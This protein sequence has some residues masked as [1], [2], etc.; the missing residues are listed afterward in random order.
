MITKGEKILITGAGGF[1]GANL[2]RRLIKEKCEVHALVKKNSNPWRLVDV[3]ND[4]TFQFVDLSDAK[5]LSIIVR[6]I[7]PRRVFHLATHGAYAAQKDLSQMIETNIIGT[8]NLLSALLT[9]PYVSFVNTGTSSEYG[10]KKK[11][12]KESDVL[13]PTSLYAA[14]KASSTLIAQVFAKIYHTSIVTLRPFSAYGPWEEP[15]RLVPTAM[16]AILKNSSIDLTPGNHRRDFIFVEDLIDAYLAASDASSKVSGM[17]F[18][19]GTGKQYT[20]DQLVTTLM[21]ISGK[22]IQVNKGK[23]PARMWDTSC[24]VADTAFANRLLHWKAKYSLSAGLKKTYL[25]FKKN[26]NKYYENDER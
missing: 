5:N 20:N 22:K 21:K 16:M 1:L 24:W 11:P 13:E 3:K 4:I 17:I 19:I 12:M 26:G 9:I 15:S 23:S 18:N 2:V 6:S 10:W 14:T 8:S 25:W 7:Q